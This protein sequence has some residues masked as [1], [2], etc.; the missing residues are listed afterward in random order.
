MAPPRVP[1]CAPERALFAAW[2][3]RTPG[4]A[5]GVSGISAYL[6]FD[7]A[8]LGLRYERQQVL[9]NN[10]AN[11]DTPDFK[12]RDFRFAQALEAA[13]GSAAGEPLAMEASSVRDLP[14][15]AETSPA[16][17][18][19]RVPFQPSLDGN[20]VD[21]NAERAELTDNALQYETSL[22][23]LKGKLSELN[24]AMQPIPGA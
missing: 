6:A 22:T 15:S 8:A 20:T 24:T 17:L 11:A 14:P 18:L 10:V 3:Q 5:G 12:A 21:M 4:Y 2:A 7:S 13:T 19:Y 16:A 9:S 23:L 1:S